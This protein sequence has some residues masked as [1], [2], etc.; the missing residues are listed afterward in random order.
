MRGRWD[1][2]VGG[3]GETCVQQRVLDFNTEY[4]DQ[5]DHLTFDFFEGNIRHDGGW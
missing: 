1:V 5:G 3:G 4:V 2:C